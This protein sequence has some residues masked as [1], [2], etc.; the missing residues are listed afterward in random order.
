MFMF[1]FWLLLFFTTS[2]TFSKTDHV[3]M[4]CIAC[5]CMEGNNRINGEN[6]SKAVGL[7]AW[8]QI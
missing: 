3:Y 8:A 4:Y 5:R 7:I 2:A 1:M 6:G